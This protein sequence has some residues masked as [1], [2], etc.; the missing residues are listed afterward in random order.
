MNDH[1]ELVAFFSKKEEAKDPIVEI[2]NGDQQDVKNFKEV[3]KKNRENEIKSIATTLANGAYKELEYATTNP[4]I[5]M[6]E[7]DKNTESVEEFLGKYFKPG[8]IK[9]VEGI[10]TRFIST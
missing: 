4:E 3:E 1:S 2:Q 8:T 6:L 10:L 9:T 7:F 5:F